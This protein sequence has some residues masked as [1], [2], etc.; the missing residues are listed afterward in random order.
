MLGEGGRWEGRRYSS[1]AKGI[2][3]YG[4]GRRFRY[5]CERELGGGEG[6][7]GRRKSSKEEIERERRVRRRMKE[8]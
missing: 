4:K 8:E 6:G 2:M 1:V 5:V 7:E 3:I